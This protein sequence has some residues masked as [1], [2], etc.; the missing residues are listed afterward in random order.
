MAATISAVAT[1]NSPTH[2]QTRLMIPETWIPHRR[3]DGELVGWIDMAVAEPRL[4]PFDRLGRPLGPVDDWFEAEEALD[5]IGLRF[6]AE[7]FVYSEPGSSDAGPLTVRIAHVYDD[8]IVLTTALT[9][10]I[11]DVG[12]E[13][14]LPFPAPDDLRSA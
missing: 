1:T 8:R 10:A 14:V 11:E 9:D 6:L 5:A 4:V 2:G 3:D 7:R 13:I 12:R